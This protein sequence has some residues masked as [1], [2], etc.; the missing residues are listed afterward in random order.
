MIQCTTDIMA[1]GSEF[2]LMCGFSSFNR[3]T[4]RDHKCHLVWLNYHGPVFMK[5]KY[6]K[7]FPEK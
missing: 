5:S 1:D 6:Y 7:E 4:F 3:M 2:C